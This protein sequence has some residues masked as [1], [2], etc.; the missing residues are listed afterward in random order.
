MGEKLSLED[1]AKQVAKLWISGKKWDINPFK[2]YEEM[3]EILGFFKEK[4]YIE[5]MFA[6]NK[7]FAYYDFTEKGKEWASSN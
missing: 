2:Q 5:L 1:K 3:K 7:Y 6:T 4:E